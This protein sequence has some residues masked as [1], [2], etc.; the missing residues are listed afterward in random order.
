MWLFFC[1]VSGCC[2]DGVVGCFI[3]LGVLQWDVDAGV[4]LVQIASPLQCFAR[5]GFVRIEIG[6]NGRDVL[7]KGRLKKD[8]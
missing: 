1:V 6:R 5:A 2:K 3:A 7:M 4:W 8:R